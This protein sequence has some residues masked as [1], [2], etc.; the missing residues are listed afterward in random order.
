M[1]DQPLTLRDIALKASDRFGGVRGRALGREAEKAGVKIV[2]TTIDKIIAGTYRSKPTDTTLQALATL[3]QVPL[4][5]VYL[6]AER[7][8]PQARL[9][10]QLPAGSDLLTPSQREAVIVLVRQFIRANREAWEIR[11]QLLSTLWRGQLSEQDR[12]TIQMTLTR[13][14][15]QYPELQRLV[16]QD[17]EELVQDRANELLEETG[18]DYRKALDLAWRD[19]ETSPGAVSRGGAAATLAERVAET[20]KTWLEEAGA[21]VEPPGDSPLDHEHLI[22]E[23][24]ARLV[25]ERAANRTDT[26]PDTEDEPAS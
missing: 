6:A 10:D 15:L 7:P 21:L 13:L 18:H 8:L 16:A 17:P 3:A 11:N 26:E 9:A 23:A 4:E 2:Y 14:E 20:L 12:R 25:A 22:A 19:I 5:D 1:G 24:E